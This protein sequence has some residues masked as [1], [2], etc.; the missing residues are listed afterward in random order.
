MKYELELFNKIAELFLDKESNEPVS[1][2]IHPE[3]IAK[4][5]NFKL[6]DAPIDES[7]FEKALTEIVLKSPKTSSKLFFNQLYGGRKNLATLGDLLSVLMN[8]SMYTYK[9]AGV[10]VAL[11]KEIISKVC[12]QINYPKDSDGTMPPGGSSA[13]LMAMIL[14]R[15]FVNSDIRFKGITSTLIVYTSINSHYSIPKNAAFIGVGRDNVRY[16]KSDDKGQM[17]PEDLEAQIQQDIANGYQPFFL[18]ATAGTT[19]LGAFDPFEKLAEICQLYGVWFHI[20]GAYCG[21]VIFSEKYKHLIKGIEASDSFCFN[22][23]KILSVPLTCSVFVTKHKKQLYDSISNDADYLYQADADEYNLG[24][25]SIQCGRRNDALKFWTLWK[26]I[27]TQGL[28]Q[29]VDKLF[30]LAD[31]ARNYIS[32]HPD[33]ELYSFE[34][35]LSVCFTYKNIDSK[36]LCTRLYEQSEALVSFG[37]YAEKTFVRLVI[38]NSENSE[39]DLLNF[40]NI[41]EKFKNE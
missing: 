24:K 28:G 39:D 5:V 22:A 4:E 21:P 8:N 12:E 16:I 6:E 13:N 9:V 30:S 36:D 15:D 40:F 3:N 29:M 38:V 18:N 20:D 37:I 26:Q 19:V 14:A 10:Q 7:E 23:H 2:Y 41:I 1:K 11:E 27:G 34:N 32:N 31:F 35:T 33:Y 17:I 25:T